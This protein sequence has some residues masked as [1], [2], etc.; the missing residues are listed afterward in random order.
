MVP[1]IFDDSFVLALILTDQSRQPEKYVFMTSQIISRLPTDIYRE[2]VSSGSPTYLIEEK[3]PFEMNEWHDFAKRKDF[4]VYF[5][6]SRVRADL[7]VFGPK[8]QIRR[9]SMTVL[10]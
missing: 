5:N 1:R 7:A 2:W 9:Y 10:D 3:Y 8:E 6:A 4:F